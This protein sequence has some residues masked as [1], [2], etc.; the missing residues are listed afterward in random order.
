MLKK[1]YE[2]PFSVWLALSDLSKLT[3]PLPLAFGAAFVLFRPHLMSLRNLI[4]SS[5]RQ[6]KQE[7]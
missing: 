6:V 1:L 7:R 3:S 4:Q 2:K 5:G